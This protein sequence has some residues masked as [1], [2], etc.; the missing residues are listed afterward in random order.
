MACLKTFLT[1]FL[2][3]CSFNAVFSQ[4]YNPYGFQCSMNV[5]NPPEPD[6]LLIG[7]LYKPESIDVYTSDP[8]AFFPV[9]FVFV[10]FPN[11][12]GPDANYWAKA[13]AP[14]YLNQVIATDKKTS[15][16][17]WDASNYPSGIY[18]YTLETGDIKISRKMI[19]LK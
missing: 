12:P 8:Q 16:S 15:A 11:D 2:L 6:N 13:S 3:L 18:I 4:D 10:Q 19:L 17:W 5:Q 1:L 7:G 14:V 9:L